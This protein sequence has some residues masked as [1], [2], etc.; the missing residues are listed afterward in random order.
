MEPPQ[1]R[2]LRPTLALLA[3]FLGLGLGY[4]YVGE[5]RFAVATVAGVYLILGLF[6][7]TRLI[8]YS[9]WILWIFS[10]IFIAIFSVSLI[11]PIIYAIRNRSRPLKR[12]NRWWFYTAWVM[13]VAALSIGGY[14]TRAWLFGYET[15]RIPTE[16]MS[17]TLQQ[18][19]FFITNAWRYRNSIPSI[20]D[21][22][23]YERPDKPGIKYVKRVVALP[24]DR[25]EGHDSII[26]RNGTRVSEPYLHAPRDYAPYGRDFPP[27]TLDSR[28]VFLL[29]DFRDNSLDSRS[30][31]PV[32]LVHLSGR[33]EYIWLSFANGHFL[34]ER[35]GKSLIP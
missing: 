12:Y 24:G 21:I 26:F 8:V 20:G 6:A 7:W 3:N 28:S 25:I 4:V 29:G 17:P 34:W 30:T 31:G 32:P 14:K 1:T 10:G 33:A 9:A 15:F 19:D 35:M 22:V 11:H 16:S 18:G 5:L 2:K 27:T 23:V 13:G